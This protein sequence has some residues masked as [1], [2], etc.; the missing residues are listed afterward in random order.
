MQVT[1]HAKVTVDVELIDEANGGVTAALKELDP[2]TTLPLQSRL[3]KGRYRL[4]CTY[5][6]KTAANKPPFK[7]RLSSVVSVTRGVPTASATPAVVPVTTADMA[8]PVAEYDSYG[9]GQITLL[10]SEVAALQQDLKS[11]EMTQAKSDWLRAELTFS[12]IGGTYGAVGH[13]QNDINGLPGG[14]PGG[15]AS[16]YFLG[17]HKIEYLLWSGQSASAIEPFV[18][19]LARFLDKLQM[20]WATGVITGNQ[21]ATRAHEILEDTLRD[22]LSGD[23]DLGSNASLAILTADIQGDQVILTDLTPVLDTRT[24]SLLP[25]AEAEIAILDTALKSTMV[26]GQWPALA[27]LTSTQMARIDG[28][29]G[30]VL[31]T[32]SAVPDLLEIQ[33]FTNGSVP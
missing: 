33:T 5:D 31:E 24:A 15:A 23:D 7:H 2:G 32:L 18:T 6:H 19:D 30:Q 14:V 4:K 3:A 27:S 17:L 1:N 12:T 29:V 20:L 28:A 26:N 8:Q 13:L 22:T 16:Q 21:L 25:K 10:Q 11:G 9:A